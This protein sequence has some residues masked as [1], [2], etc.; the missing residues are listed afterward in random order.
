MESVISK[1]CHSAVLEWNIFKYILQIAGKTILKGS[2]H[3][4][5][6]FYRNSF[7]NYFKVDYFSWNCIHCLQNFERGHTDTTAVYRV[8]IVS[9]YC[10]NDIQSRSTLLYI[11]LINLVLYEGKLVF[12]LKYRNFFNV[13]QYDT[14]NYILLIYHLK[15]HDIRQKLNEED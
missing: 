5:L 13:S 2:I 14:K 7:V 9:L 10:Q 3:S 11:C 12:F 15:M 4:S 8:C 6:H 1:F